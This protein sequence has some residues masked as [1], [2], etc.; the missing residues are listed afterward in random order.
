MK[1]KNPFVEFARLA[2]DRGDIGSARVW[3]GLARLVGRKLR[4][5]KARYMEDAKGVYERHKYENQSV[6]SHNGSGVF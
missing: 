6:D 1:T 2:R 3:V 4:A 5:L